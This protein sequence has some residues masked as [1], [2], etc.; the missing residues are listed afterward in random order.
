LKT[1][2]AGEVTS[3]LHDR[4][5]S[6]VLHSNCKLE[7]KVCHRQITRRHPYIHIQT[8]FIMHTKCLSK[9]ATGRTSTVLCQ[10]APSN[11]LWHFHF[12]T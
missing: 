11:I 5:K 8:T 9:S 4:W 3:L 1:V 12:F 10:M 7:G 2:K 6:Y